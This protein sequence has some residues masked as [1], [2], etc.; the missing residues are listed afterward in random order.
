[1]RRNSYIE[2]LQEQSNHPIRKEAE[3]LAN[4]FKTDTYKD[5]NYVLRW[6]SNNSVPPQ[7]V[8]DF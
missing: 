5:N 1:M 8:L 3:R 4:K 6:K 7:E 2:A